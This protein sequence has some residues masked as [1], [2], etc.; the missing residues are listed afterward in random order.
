MAMVKR[1]SPA[2][3]LRTTT[4]LLALML[5]SSAP[6]A[7]QGAPSDTARIEK[8]KTTVVES[9]DARRKLAQVI[10]DTVF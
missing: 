3:K 10:N 4:A 5:A 9:V 2:M 1:G 6:L 7:Q 8:F